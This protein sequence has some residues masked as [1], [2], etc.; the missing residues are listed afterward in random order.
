MS[1]INLVR[2]VLDKQML[3]QNECEIGRVD[4]IILE[5]PEDG[6]PRVARLELGGPVLARRLGDWAK[7][8][9]RAMSE[10][11]GPK[12]LLPVEFP[13]RL[14]FRLGS[15]VH[16]DLDAEATDALAWEKWIEKKIIKKIPGAMAK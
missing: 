13:W 8:P 6:P 9:I 12:R 16:L 11:F 5:F 4:G 7:R 2:D 15:D 3:D 14:V 1:K 10:R